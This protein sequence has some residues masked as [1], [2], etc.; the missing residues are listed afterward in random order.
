MI[1]EIACLWTIWMNVWLCVLMIPA[2]T[3]KL[4]C[5]DDLWIGSNSIFINDFWVNCEPC[6][7][8]I[9]TSA[10]K[11]CCVD[12]FWVG[13]DS[14]FIN[15]FWV[16]CEPCTLMILAST[17]KLCCVD[18]LWVGSNSVLSKNSELAVNHVHWQFQ[19]QLW[20]FVVLC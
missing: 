17:V 10:V 2:S 19:H 16:R 6:T 13:N 5:V 3:V 14:V 4:C 12:D 9:S 8:M 18:D 20:N 15:D 7:L 11:L 1:G